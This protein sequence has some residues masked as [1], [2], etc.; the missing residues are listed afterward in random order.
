[1]PPSREQFENQ[2]GDTILDDFEEED[3]D[4]DEGVRER[5]AA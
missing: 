1:M 3:V 2:Y 4:S 5:T